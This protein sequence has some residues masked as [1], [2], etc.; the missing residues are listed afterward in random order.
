MEIEN[1]EFSKAIEG[2][3]DKVV[4][5]EVKK[6]ISDLYAR[7]QDFENENMQIVITSHKLGEITNEIELECLKD[8][9]SKE[10]D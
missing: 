10:A 5:R 4:R 7:L 2:I 9:Q 8:Y 3:V 1:K 6:A